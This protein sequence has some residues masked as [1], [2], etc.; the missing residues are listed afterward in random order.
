[1]VRTLVILLVI[2][3]IIGCGSSR[4]QQ[5]VHPEEMRAQPKRLQKIFPVTSSSEPNIKLANRIR[6]QSSTEN[7]RSVIYTAYLKIASQEQDSVHE[8]VVALTKEYDGYVLKSELH[9]TTIRI[10]AVHLKTVI[11][12]IEKT[13][14]VLTKNIKGTDVTGDFYDFK[15]RLENAKKTRDRYLQLLDKAVNVKDIL[16]IE[17]ELERMNNSIDFL[18]GKINK[19][20]HQIQFA[21]ITVETSKEIKP[22]IVGSVFTEIY[23]GVKWLF[24]R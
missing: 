8:A 20:S 2:V 10:D 24:V 13:G 19:M 1:M 5:I 6:Q 15:I 21:T 23:K 22:G 7:N 12:K 11:E 18:E 3:S 4:T 16:S 9:R 17:K 14:K